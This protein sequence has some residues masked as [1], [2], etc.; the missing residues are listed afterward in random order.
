MFTYTSIT[1]ECRCLEDLRTLS[2][3]N[4]CIY[5]FQRLVEVVRWFGRICE[6]VKSM[7]CLVIFWVDFTLKLLND[8]FFNATL[9]YYHL[10][11]DDWL[12]NNIDYFII[13]RII[14]LYDINFSNMMIFWYNFI[15]F[16][17]GKKFS[18]HVE[19]WFYFVKS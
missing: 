16:L 17:N 13:F 8:I 19:K 10:V 7:S 12:I 6:F 1:I 3:G 9:W 18:G 15:F 2:V 11:S 5:I 14:M 4:A